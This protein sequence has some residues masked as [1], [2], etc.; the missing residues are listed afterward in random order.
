MGTLK[1]GVGS[2]GFGKENDS[3]KGPAFLSMLFLQLPNKTVIFVIIVCFV[4]N[5]Y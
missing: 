4:G 1:A 3:L 5:G 2:K